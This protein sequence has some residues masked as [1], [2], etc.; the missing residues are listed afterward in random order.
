MDVLD[1]IG[2]SPTKLQIFQMRW[3]YVPWVHILQ[4]LR[5]AKTL[6][7]SVVEKDNT[8]FMSVGGSY[9]SCNGILDILS[10]IG[11]SCGVY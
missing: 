11:I 10:L 5:G 8:Q 6:A 7:L 4:M 1:L 3:S 9:R 2:Y